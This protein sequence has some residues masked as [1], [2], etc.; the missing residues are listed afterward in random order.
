MHNKLIA[1]G[2]GLFSFGAL[3]GWAITG[4]HFERRMKS[5]QEVLNEVIRRKSEEINLLKQRELIDYVEQD[6]DLTMAMLESRRDEN[7]PELPF[8]EKA[9]DEAEPEPEEAEEEDEWEEEY[10]EEKT[11]ELRT[12]LQNL[13]DSY[14]ANPN[15]V[16]TFVSRA[17]RVMKRDHTPPFVISREKYAWDEEEGDDYSKITLTYY[18][19][20]RLLLDDDEDP[21][22][23]VNALVGWRSLS[24]FGGESGDPDVVFVRNRHLMTDF[25]VVR[26]EENPI[27]L[28][29]KYGMSRA[30]FE[31]NKAAG[32][33]KFRP[34]D[35]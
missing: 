13:I 35:Q 4:D 6:V 33:I 11:E 18:P 27:P 20:E 28:H 31:T 22:D 9:E 2:A 26:D 23:D 8:Q 32:V 21:V 24:Q 30:E 1:A 25:E 12:N 5:N 10:S 3:V 17:G 19:N 29:V 16:D 34:E 15:D 7:Q 14:T